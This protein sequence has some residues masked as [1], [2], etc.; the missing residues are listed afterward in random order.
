M[1]PRATPRNRSQPRGKGRPYKPVELLEAQAQVALLHTRYAG[2]YARGTDVQVLLVFVCHRWR[3][4]TDNLAKT[5]LDALQPKLL[6]K[7][8]QQ[9]EVWGAGVYHDDRQVRELRAVWVKVPTAQPE[10]VRLHMQPWAE[11]TLEELWPHDTI[12][13]A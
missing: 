10:G 11:P 6:G 3:G 13:D 7:V 5:V 12:T 2:T 4:D 9:G 1:R 8:A